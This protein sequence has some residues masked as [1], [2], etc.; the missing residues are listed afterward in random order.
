[1]SLINTLVSTNVSE[2]SFKRFSAFHEDLHRLIGWSKK[3]EAE[4]DHS[5]A[6]N[7]TSLALAFYVK[8]FNESMNAAQRSGVEWNQGSIE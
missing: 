1:M 2:F 7:F 3:G 5:I 4:V 6:E 8:K